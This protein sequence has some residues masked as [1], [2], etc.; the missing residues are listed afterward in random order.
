MISA[1]GGI[2]E[3]ENEDDIQTALDSIPDPAGTFYRYSLS[4]SLL[5]RKR[6]GK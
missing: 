6:E 3:Q 4:S 2:M 5:G 1:L